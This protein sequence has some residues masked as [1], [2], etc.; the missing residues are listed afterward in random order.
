MMSSQQDYMSWTNT[1]SASLLRMR[2]ENL[3]YYL[4]HGPR[5]IR[6]SNYMVHIW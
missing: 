6:L 5:S 1:S 2:P 4:P 3:W